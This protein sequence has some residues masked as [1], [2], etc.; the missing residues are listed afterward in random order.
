MHEYY[1]IPS[2]ESHRA[3]WPHEIFLIN[4]VF[5]HIL[6]FATTFGV[7][8][9]FPFLVLIVPLTSFAITV[10]IIVKAR[11]IAAS[12]ETW[13][14]KS[15]WVIAARRNLHFMW[16]L[17]ITCGFIAGGLGLA[18]LSGWSRITT[19]SLIGGFGLLP[20]MVSLLILIVLGND[21]LYQA[22][23]GKLPKRFVEN[24]PPPTTSL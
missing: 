11:Q 8:R 17:S 7:Y 21:S 2:D 13:F 16:L 19:L 15:H 3:K 24:N 20:F 4:L 12:D 22:R 1:T 10:Y 5:N 6:I 18:Y 23:H 14:V 9:T